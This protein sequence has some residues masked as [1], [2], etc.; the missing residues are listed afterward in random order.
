MYLITFPSQLSTLNW[1][2]LLFRWVFLGIKLGS[3][4]V[5]YNTTTSKLSMASS[6]IWSLMYGRMQCPTSSGLCRSVGMHVLVPFH[7]RHPPFHS[8]GRSVEQATSC[9]HSETVVCHIITWTL[10]QMRHL[11]DGH[12]M[13]LDTSLQIL[14]FYVTA[15]NWGPLARYHF[16]STIVTSCGIAYAM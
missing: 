8:D 9:A 2:F 4:F 15:S 7:R 6:K 1:C 10:T 12:W 16:M 5:C 14:L 13:Y 11:I 3:A